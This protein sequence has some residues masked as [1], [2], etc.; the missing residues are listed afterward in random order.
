M[1]NFYDISDIRIV[2]RKPMGVNCFVVNIQY[3]KY[4]NIKY[5]KYYYNIREQPGTSIVITFRTFFLYYISPKMCHF[6]ISTYYY[7]QHNA[8]CKKL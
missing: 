6:F 2:L 7:Y 4:V 5:L 8:S 1:T 3:V